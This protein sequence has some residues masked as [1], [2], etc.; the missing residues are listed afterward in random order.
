MRK[1]F[2]ILMVLVFALSTVSLIGCEQK[3]EEPKK[4]EK[5]AEGTKAETRCSP[6]G[7]CCTRSSCYTCSSCGS[8]YTPRSSRRQIVLRTSVVNSYYLSSEREIPFGGSL[9][10]YPPTITAFHAKI[11]LL[12]PVA[13]QRSFHAWRL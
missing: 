13:K 1:L 5:K 8:C 6:R 9:S 2:V 4:D 12:F 3:K 7:S 10:F 11:A